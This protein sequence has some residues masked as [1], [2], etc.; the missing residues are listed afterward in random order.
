VNRRTFLTRAA[1]LAGGALVGPTA[2]QRITAHRDWADAY[3]YDPGQ[4]LLPS[5]YGPLVRTPDLTTGRE[6]LAL[7]AGF[8][9]GRGAG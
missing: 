1:L 8:R 6:I 7:P 3:A 5:S 2:L 9:Y 4:P